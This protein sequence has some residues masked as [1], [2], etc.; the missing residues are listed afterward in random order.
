MR[1]TAYGGKKFILHQLRCANDEC[2]KPIGT[3]MMKP[4]DKAMNEW[5]LRVARAAEEL[6]RRK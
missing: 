2:D 3:P 5:N 6:V 1:V 4:F